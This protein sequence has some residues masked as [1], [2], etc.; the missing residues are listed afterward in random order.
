MT[1]MLLSMISLILTGIIPA[2]IMGMAKAAMRTNA[3]LLAESRV[4]QIQQSGFGR[5]QATVAPHETHLVGKTEYQLRVEVE[6]ARLSSG[7][8]MEDDVA[9]LI[10][11]VVT[12]EDKN[13]TQTCTSQAVMFKRI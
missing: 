13:G 10:R 4:A 8:F 9:K 5:V 3:S 2:T 1:L 7:D 6:P 12:W 11:V